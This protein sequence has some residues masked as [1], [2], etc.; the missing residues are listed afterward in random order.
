MIRF[1]ELQNLVKEPIFWKQTEDVFFEA[2]DAGYASEKKPNKTEVIE[3]AGSKCITHVQ[4]PWNVK[5]VY[6]VT[7]LSQSSGGMTVIEYEDVPVWMMQYVGSYDEEATPCLKAALRD[8]YTKRKFCGGRG[9]NRFK[10]EGMTYTNPCEKA[11]QFYGFFR[12]EEQVRGKDYRL[13]GWH[14]YQGGPMV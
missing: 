3:L 7:P 9:T 6:L 14:A 12:G 4:L 10:F 1:A 11:T 13:L 5:D 8:A 2:M